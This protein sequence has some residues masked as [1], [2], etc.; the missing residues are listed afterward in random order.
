MTQHTCTR[1]SAQHGPDTAHS[2]QTRA[3]DTHSTHTTHARP[4][5]RTWHSTRVRTQHTRSQQTPRTHAQLSTDSRPGHAVPPHSCP[6]P[7]EPPQRRCILHTHTAAGVTLILEQIHTPARGRQQSDPGMRNRES[8][9]RL[10]PVPLTKCHH[11][12]QGAR[13]HSRPWQVG[14]AA[15]WGGLGA[16][17]R[18]TCLVSGTRFPALLSWPFAIHSLWVPSWTEESLPSS[19]VP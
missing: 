15:R 9:G 11:D 10:L 17:G 19:V 18:A 2:R 16:R 1:Q 5:T 7:P 4:D 13:L 12:G 8:L 3:H 6:H 14:P